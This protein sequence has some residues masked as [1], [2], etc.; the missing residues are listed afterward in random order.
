MAEVPYFYKHSMSG[1]E[2]ERQSLALLC[3]AI[4]IS[5]MCIVLM[6]SMLY[7]VNYSYSITE[8]SGGL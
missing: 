8:L 1:T 3:I 6:Y 4:C 7:C 2:N 5:L